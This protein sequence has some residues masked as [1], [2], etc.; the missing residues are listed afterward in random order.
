MRLAVPLVGQRL[1]PVGLRIEGF[2]DVH[3][4][5][6]YTVADDEWKALK[7]LLKDQCERRAA[8]LGRAGCC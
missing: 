8:L 6:W 1:V 5:L 4:L 2:L 7:R 3:G